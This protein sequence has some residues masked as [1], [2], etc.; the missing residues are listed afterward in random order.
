MW[1]KDFERC[2]ICGRND[3]K[4]MA[5]GK[6]KFCYLFEYRQK[7]ENFFRAKQSK[8]KWYL[9]NVTQEQQKIKREQ[10]HFDGKRQE[11]LERD[12]FKCQMCGN[13]ALSMLTVHH[14][15]GNGRGSKKVNND[16]D[17]LQTLCRA[18]HAKVHGTIIQW[19]K[20]YTQCR[21]CKTTE[22]RHNAKGLCWKCYRETKGK[23]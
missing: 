1:S 4:H 9:N 14:K 13:N 21:R 8:N 15:D 18:C 10:L 23:F 7:P 17:N 20:N 2:V 3:R 19:A 22:R 16:L 12:N 6:C 5:K 11:V